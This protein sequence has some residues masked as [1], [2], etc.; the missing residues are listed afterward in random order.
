[1]SSHFLPKT[2]RSDFN[3]SI[4]VFLV[5]LPLCLGIALASRSPL[6]AGLVA[7]I[8]GGIV[9]SSLTDSR[10]SVSGPAAGLAVIVAKGIEDT[11]GFP[12]FCVSVFLAGLLQ[13]VFSRVKAGTL[14]NF[15]PASVIN[16]ML[17]AIGL[18]LILKQIPHAVGWDSAFMGS[19]EFWQLEDGENTFSE[20]I[21]AFQVF[22][23]EC[24]FVAASSFLVIKVWDWIRARSSNILVRSIPSALLAVIF[25]IVLS[26]WVFGYFGAELDPKHRVD[27]PFQGGFGALLAGLVRPDWGAL[28]KPVT[29]VVALTIAIVGSLES[30]LSID[31]ADKI[32][33]ERRSSSK[34]RELLSQGVANTISGF[35]GGLPITAVIVR[36][37]ANVDAGA[38]GRASGILHGLWLLLAVVAIPG[39]LSL[40]PLS[41]LAVV[42]IL[43]GYKLTRPEMYLKVYRKGMDQFIPFLVT[44]IAILMTDLLKGIGIGMLVGFI[45]VIK[46]SHHKSLIMVNDGGHYL[47]R[48]MKDI[49]FLHKHDLML[50]FRSIP[51]GAIVHVDGGGD[52]HVDDDVIDLIEDF[53]QGARIKG[54]QVNIKKS[55]SALSPYFRG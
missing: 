46:R 22:D 31:A 23:L 13:V 8:I 6:S 41:V 50:C 44:I 12:A 36:T 55:K 1:M 29:Y 10:L 21:R 30:L 26:R 18:L 52:V 42:L 3:A 5:A 35:L 53:V 19:M 27:L 25:G 2:F 38:Q 16:G 40:I 15:F 43:V 47:I 45:F 54:I 24:L 48:F 37:S 20:L 9:V 33:P 7:G 39:I 4:V 34:N 14:G 17:A 28:G 11:G 51:S 32:D 49:S